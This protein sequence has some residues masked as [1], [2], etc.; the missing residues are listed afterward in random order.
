MEKVS[1]IVLAYNTEKYI[2]ECLESIVNQTYKNIE[3]IVIDDGSKDNT[4]QIVE[5]MSLNDNRIKLYSRSNKGTYYSRIEGYKMSTGKYIMYVDSDDVIELNMVEIMYNAIIRNESSIVHCQNKLYIGDN[6]IESK[7][8]FI[9]EINLSSNDLEPYFYDLLYKTI[10]CNPVWKQLYARDVLI[11]I[12]DSNKSL[13]YGEDLYCNIKAYQQMNKIT[14]IP[15]QLYIYRVNNSGITRNRNKDNIIRKIDDVLYVYK[16]LF[17]S[18]ELF[19]IKAREHYKSVVA[20]KIY[21]YLTINL[22]QLNSM[23]KKEFIKYVN[24]VL[25]DNVFKDIDYALI[26]DKKNYKELNINNKFTKLCTSLLVKK[27]LKTLYYIS[28]YIYNPLKKMKR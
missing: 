28:K 12:D 3:V 5:N 7:K 27:N 21:Y 14:F 8:I 1:I 2:Q 13:M 11:D 20:F 19:N 6:I 10:E 23:S 4:K 25:S 26:N 15:E 24:Q 18:V 9:E 17:D 16:Y 22:L